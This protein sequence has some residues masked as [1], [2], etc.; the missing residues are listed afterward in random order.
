MPLIWRK[1]FRS[2][3]DHGSAKAQSKPRRPALNVYQYSDLMT[4]TEI[5][6]LYLNPGSDNEPL[7]GQLINADISGAP[8]YSVLSYTWG[9]QDPAAKLRLGEA[10][11][12]ITSNLELALLQMRS[13][14]HIQV[15]W[16]DSIC[17]NQHDVLER[18]QQV[19]L[20]K[21]VFV[22]TGQAMQLLRRVH[23]TDPFY[24]PSWSGLRRGMH[25]KPSFLSIVEE[26]VWSI[27]EALEPLNPGIIEL[28][29]DQNK[30]VIRGLLLD[31]ITHLGPICDQSR[32]SG[33][34]LEPPKWLTKL[35]T[36]YTTSAPRASPGDVISGSSTAAS[37]SGPSSQATLQVRYNDFTTSL[38][39]L[40]DAPHDPV[41]SHAQGSRQLPPSQTSPNHG[42]ASNQYFENVKLCVTEAGFLGLV[43]PSTRAG[44]SIFMVEQDMLKS[45]FVVRKHPV[46]GF[47]LWNG[48]ACIYDLTE[49]VDNTH[50]T[51]RI[52]VG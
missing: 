3:E 30:L 5:R 13:I 20:M 43:P 45:M 10:G 36:S 41:T 26:Q 51:I 32:F 37:K 33:Q 46:H 28:T 9:T 49:A 12:R 22:Q 34:A 48:L 42:A 27:S 15:L 38:L 50:A 14:T 25:E 8:R 35:A 31:T 4:S 11:I 47:Y 29:R 40:L 17:I 6:L 16:I 1:V 7:T 2:Q 23:L 24:S 44:D 52:L 18:N 39:S 21:Q 19:S